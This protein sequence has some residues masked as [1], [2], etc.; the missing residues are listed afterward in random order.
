MNSISG[1][2]RG[3][4]WKCIPSPNPP[5]PLGPR[6]FQ[7]LVPGRP[8]A[9][10]EKPMFYFSKIN[11]LRVRGV[12]IGVTARGSISR[13]SPGEGVGGEVNLSPLGRL[14]DQAL[15]INPQITKSLNAS[16][17][18]AGGFG[19]SLVSNLEPFWSQKTIKKGIEICL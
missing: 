15:C 7:Y 3:H 2:I 18:R 4:T 6:R 16:A 1:A 9:P 8:Q 14:I 10:F 5:P 19:S 12:E 13:G 11:I 17:P